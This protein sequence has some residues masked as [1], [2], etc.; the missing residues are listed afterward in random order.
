MHWL[1]F[2]IK[3]IHMDK[4]THLRETKTFNCHLILCTHKYNSLKSQ[5]H[6]SSEMNWIEKEKFSTTI[7]TTHTHK[8]VI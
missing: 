5:K 8:K 1:S 3:Q 4:V 6:A 7:M 2:M